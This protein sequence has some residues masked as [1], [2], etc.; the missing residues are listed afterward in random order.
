MLQNFP[1]EID[2]EFY[3]AAYSDLREHSRQDLY[4]HYKDHGC[5]EGRAASPAVARKNFVSCISNYQAALEIG[6][7]NRPLLSGRNVKYFDVLSAEELKAR[8]VDLGVSSEGV[9]HIDFVSKS[10]SVEKISGVFDV[11]LSSHCIE[12]Q[13]NLIKHLCDVEHLLRPEGCYCLIIPDFRYCFDHFIPPSTIADVLEAR[14]E[15][16]ER[17]T[18]GKV[19]EHR[20]LTCHNDPP[21]HWERDSGQPGV[22]L[23]SIRAALKEWENARGAYIDVH[24]WQFAPHTF[25]QIICLLNELGFS[26]LK[27]ARVYD[28]PYAAGEFCAVLYKPASG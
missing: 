11:V 3:R 6:P 4:Q 25:R 17:H 18:L 10:G 26:N 13:P 19:I 20:A 7:F 21:R 14:Y 27:A 16:R 12:H 22:S 28:T 9:P 5:R 15:N 24:A 8:A 23:S 2:L 1:P